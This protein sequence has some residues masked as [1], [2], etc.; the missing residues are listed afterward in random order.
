MAKTKSKMSPTEEK[1]AREILADPVLWAQAFVR[2]FDPTTNQ[3][4]PWTAR[5][6]QVEMLRDT[7]LKKV[8]RCG[9]RIGKTETMCIDILW[10]ALTR[11]NYRCLVVTPYENQVSLIFRRLR[12]LISYS[13]IIAQEVVRST[14]SPYAIEFNNGSAILG[15]TTGA[16]SGS[17]GASIRGQR[18]D[19]I[20]MDEVDYMSDAD[21]DSVTAIALERSDIGIIMSST[22]TGR[23]SQF[24][25]A[26]TDKKLGYSEHHHPSTHNPSWNEAMEAEFR[27]QLSEQGY[28]H[29]VLAE[30]GTEDAGVFPKDK[31]DAATMVEFYHYNPLNYYQIE[32]VKSLGIEPKSYDYG[33]NMAPLNPFR[34][35]GIDWDKYGA[36]SSIIILD[37]DVKVKKFKVIK[38]IEVPRSEYSYDEAVNLVVKLNDQYNPAWIFCDRGAGEYQIERLHII[39]D[40]RPKTGLKNKVVGFQFSNMLE[41]VDPVTHE[42]TKAPMKAFMVNQLQIAFERNNMILSPFDE[43]LHKQLVDYTVEKIGKNGQPV[44]TSKNEHF[45]DALGLAYLAFVL[46]TDLT[47]TIQKPEVK[48]VIEVVNK[49][50]GSSGLNKMFNSIQ[51]DFNVSKA[52]QLNYDKDERPG[53][54]PTWVKVPQ[55]Y[56]SGSSA[57][58]WGSRSPGSRGSGSRGGRSTW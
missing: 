2:T 12:E 27:A 31:V 16:S 4:V 46:K 18:A 39:G 11:K 28:I 33:E 8:Y 20:Y 44:F 32:R 57:G 52:V 35:I 49:T 6:Y 14:K 51:T 30:F 19:I 5:W 56:R 23:R 48:N 41:I 9:R 1:R 45:V 54:R 22:P 50:L 10:R 58:R 24:Y 21:F 13:P 42:I 15:F 53:D 25:K 34:T 29:E 3:T 36:S 7:S 47:Q 37:F 26:C 17:G 40:E 55:S 43:V 38:R